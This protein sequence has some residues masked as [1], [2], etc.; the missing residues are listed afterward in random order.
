MNNKPSRNF[1][2]IKPFLRMLEG[3]IDDARKRRLGHEAPPAAPAPAINGAAR[4]GLPLPSVKSAVPGN[5]IPIQ[6][7]PTATPP[8]LPQD[9][10]RPLRATAIKPKQSLHPHTGYRPAGS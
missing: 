10:E 8:A 7:G 3:S 2:Q 6:G 9:A 5:S 1:D 4:S